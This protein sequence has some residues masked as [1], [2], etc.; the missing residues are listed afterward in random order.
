[1]RRVRRLFNRAGLDRNE[2]NIIRG[3]LTAVQ[4][5]RRSD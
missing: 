4:G 3:F 2:V 5:K 1:M